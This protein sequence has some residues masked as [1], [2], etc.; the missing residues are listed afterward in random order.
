MRGLRWRYAYVDAFFAFFVAADERLDMLRQLR[1]IFRLMPSRYAIRRLLRVT[2]LRR[3]DDTADY[4]VRIDTE[5]RINITSPSRR[6]SRLRHF[7]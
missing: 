5:Y 4:A 1:I 7:R 6:R 3:D 2:M